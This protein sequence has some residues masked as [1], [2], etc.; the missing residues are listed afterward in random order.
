MTV[1]ICDICGSQTDLIE[2]NMPRFVIR[3]ICGS[4]ANVRITSFTLMEVVKT[5][6]CETCTKSMATYFNFLHEKSNN[7]KER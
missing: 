7:V 2:C 3:N 1:K 4:K 5:E 6:I